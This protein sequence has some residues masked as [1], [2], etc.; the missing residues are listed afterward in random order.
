MKS[1]RTELSAPTPP[2]ALAT[3]SAPAPAPAAE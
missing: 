2:A 1:N 3:H